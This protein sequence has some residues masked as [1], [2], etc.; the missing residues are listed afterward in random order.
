M[1]W[2]WPAAVVGS[3]A[4]GALVVAGAAL[5]ALEPAA[6]TIWLALAGAVAGAEW[7]ALGLVVSRRDRSNIM[8]ALVALVALGVAFTTTREIAWRVL[9]PHPETLASLDWLVAVLAE[10]SI[11]LLAALA[12]VLPYFPDGRL[13]SARW[14]PVPAVLVVAA[15]VHHAYGAVDTAP[16]RA[17]L[18]DLPH[19]FG[20]P[21]TAVSALASLGELA[22]LVL[23]IACAAAPVVRFRRAGEA[24]RRQ[25]KWLALAGVGVPAFIVV[26]LGEVL[27][28]GQPKWL[29]LTIAIVTI[30]GL[31]V[32][33]GI[34]ML[35]A[36]VYDVDKALTETVGFVLA[37]AFVL[38]LFAVA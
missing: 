20:P 19:P 13:P 23:V 22:L 24:R 38:V 6:S 26:C 35:R 36:D 10:S 33:I 17:P 7:A 11:W 18:Q 5:A 1:R 2:S 31:P 8:G 15:F 34:A 28:L 27:I 14:R 3:A 4:T 25:L 32:A 9:A 30:L 37:S 21:P 12:L 16:F 29:S